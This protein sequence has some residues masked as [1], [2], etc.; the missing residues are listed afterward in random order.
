MIKYE[1][2]ENGNDQK[3]KKCF[4]N[5]YAAFRRN[6]SACD[7]ELLI[8]FLKKISCCSVLISKCCEI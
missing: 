6:E 2:R 4:E 8:E 5:K 7:A 1:S 3:D